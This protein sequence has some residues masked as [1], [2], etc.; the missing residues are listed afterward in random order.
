MQLRRR[1]HE[2]KK[3]ASL[4]PAVDLVQQGVI[5]SQLVKS[6]LKNSSWSSNCNSSSIFGRFHDL[7]IQQ[8]TLRNFGSYGD[9]AVIYPVNNRGMVLLRGQ[10]DDGSG[11][12]SNGSGKVSWVTPFS[13]IATYSTFSVY[14]D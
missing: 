9:K 13:T 7:E 10:V 4:Q 2:A 14:T 6:S 12:D 5:D 1:T 3:K 8:V 11:A